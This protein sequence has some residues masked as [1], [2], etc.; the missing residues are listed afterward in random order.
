MNIPYSIQE[1]RAATHELV[2]ANGL[3]TCYIRPI[4]F[5][6]Y[7]ELGVSRDRKPR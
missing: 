6:G 2:T 4:A 3:P 5:F 1:L 7:G